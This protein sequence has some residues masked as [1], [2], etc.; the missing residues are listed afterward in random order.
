[1]IH[2]EELLSKLEILNTP[3]HLSLARDYQQFL[4]LQTIDKEMA[5][6]R[7]RRAVERTAS[8]LYQD[9]IGE[10]GKR[11]LHE[12]IDTLRKE[13]VIDSIIYAQFILIKEMGN[14]G[15]HIQGD[16]PFYEEIDES[17][18]KLA[19]QAIFLIIKYYLSKASHTPSSDIHSL[20]TIFG[21]DLAE[22]RLVEL[23]HLDKLVYSDRVAVPLDVFRRWYKKNRQA[24]IC[25]EDISIRSIVGY[26]CVLP[27]TEQSFKKTLEADFEE[28]DLQADEILDYS[29][30]DFYRAYLCSI[31]VDPSYQNISMVYK[32][33]IDSYIHQ[34]LNLAKSDIFIFELSAMTVSEE[35]ARICKSLH[36]NEAGTNPYHK[37]SIYHSFMLPP[38]FC[39]TNA[40][41]VQLYKCYER[42]YLAYK[43]MIHHLV[44]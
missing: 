26:V 27:L 31:V 32:K 17:S 24:F 28:Q 41:S 5:L 23:V 36:M 3:F 44:E 10:P 39:T 40:D 9:C 20:Q 42:K 18:I 43:D 21:K 33:L 35:G 6:V 12:I 16:D 30:P 29:V 1:M 4:K 37:A 8:R 13:K 25:I 22:D 19:E 38:S 7:G 11:Q 2:P 15:A 34:L 14:W